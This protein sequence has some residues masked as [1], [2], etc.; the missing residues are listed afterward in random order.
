MA[1]LNATR[2]LGARSSFWLAGIWLACCAVGSAAPASSAA[3]R[4][5]GI[6]SVFLFNFARFVAWPPNAFAAAD[7]PLVIGVLGE[8]PFGD[9]LDLA[10]KAE[11]VNGHR[12]VVR[13]FVRVEEIDT[14][15]ILFISR[16]ESGRLEAIFSALNGR[17]TL[18]VSDL[19][20]FATRGGMIRFVTDKNRIQLHINLQA[21]IAANLTLSSKLLRPAE[22]VG[23]RKS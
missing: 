1:I 18:T 23:P 22:I 15:H 19:E 4:E 9:S 20:D 5:Y 17:S 21:A 7:A 14:C 13:R 6:K 12:L 11:I 3:S 16:S 10:A 2:H 8:D